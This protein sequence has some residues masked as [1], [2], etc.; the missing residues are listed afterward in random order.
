SDLEY[1]AVQALK[2]PSGA[3]LR[4]YGERWQALLV[5]EFQDTSPIQE[6]LVWLLAGDGR[7][8]VVGDD[9]QAIYGFRGADIDVFDRVRRK[10]VE[11]KAGEEVELDIAYRTRGPLDQLT[12]NVFD[13]VLGNIAKPLPAHRP[14][15][16]V[17]GPPYFRAAY[18]GDAPKGG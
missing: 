17:A 8:T 1:Y 4:H 16:D 13:R 6:E 14:D 5:D 3:A 10:I 2:H 15:D 11:E 18:V 7:L 12:N 9:K